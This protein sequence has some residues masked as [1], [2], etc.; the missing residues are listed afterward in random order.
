[1]ATSKTWYVTLIVYWLWY[2]LKWTGKQFWETLK[3][4]W[5]SCV[6]YW[7]NILLHL[8]GKEVLRSS[9]IKQTLQFHCTP[10]AT[11]LAVK[12]D[13]P[14]NFP[15]FLKYS[16]LGSINLFSSPKSFLNPSC[17]KLINIWQYT[18]YSLFQVVT[19]RVA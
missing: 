6:S 17:L 19:T 18:C 10:F 13:G 15:F 8:Q 11:H 2:L 9:E 3:Y 1:M 14:S 7:V 4:L 5:V 16:M 12:G